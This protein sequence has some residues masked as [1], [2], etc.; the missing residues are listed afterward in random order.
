MVRH[1]PA[2]DRATKVSTK[3]RSFGRFA[4]KFQGEPGALN[5]R[6]AQTLVTAAVILGA[7]AAGWPAAAGGRGRAGAAAVDASADLA[8]AGPRRDIAE[9]RTSAGRP[10]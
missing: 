5:H 9:I 10:R 2:R 7:S 3:Q 6:P 1:A 4:L 8:G